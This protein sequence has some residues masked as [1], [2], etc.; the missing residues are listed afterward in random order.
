M[1]STGMKLGIFTLFTVIVTF[2]L[3]SIIG[4]I[5]PLKDT[6]S[7]SAVFTDATGILVG[8]PV[9]IAG[10]TVGKVN[11]FEVEGG[12][13]VVDLKIDGDVD[14]PTNVEVEMKFRNLLGQ[15]VVNLIRPETP[16][17]ETLKDGES[18][19]PTQTR[20]ALDI[21]IVFNNLRPL[22]HSTNPEDIN[23]VA[24]AVLEVFEGR[25]GDLEGI[26]GNIGSLAKTLS[27]KDQRLARLVEDLDDLTA[28]LNDQSGSISKGLREFT[29]FIESLAEV[30]PTIER[31]V[32]QLEETGDRFGGILQRNRGNLD[33]ELDDLN[34]LL[35]IVNDNLGPL[36]T[37]AKNLKEVL[38]ATA[39]S[40]SFGKWWTLYVV[41]LCV[42]GVPNL[43]NSVECER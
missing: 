34:T 17:P 38:L 18:I 1:R 36:D 31:V 28:V 22:I 43:P 41:N 29:E 10:V 24:R 20:P 25:E 37:V 13:A 14:L 42:D 40:Q 7:V 9:K 16:D 4:N 33:A 2:W 26:L 5:S 3:A 39:R 35:T 12:E 15:R 21:T 30:T 19:P 23:T 6:Y 8:D 27:D 32:N 11:G